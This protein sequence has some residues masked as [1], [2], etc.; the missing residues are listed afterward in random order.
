LNRPLWVLAWVWIGA[1]F[2][3]NTQVDR[4][5][6]GQEIPLSSPILEKWGDATVSDTRMF[7]PECHKPWGCGGAI[8]WE[9]PSNLQKVVVTA[10]IEAN[11]LPEG[12][13]E[14]YARIHLMQRDS[15]GALL[16]DL[17]HQVVGLHGS[18]WQRD[19]APF[20]LGAYSAELIAEFR[21]PT[22]DFQLHSLRVQTAQWSPLYLGLA[23]LLGVTGLLLASASIQI[24]R[25]ER[26]FWIP[27][28]VVIAAMLLPGSVR[29]LLPIS[30]H[31][32]HLLAFLV[33]AAVARKNPVA[34]LFTLAVAGEAIQTFTFDRYASWLD[35]GYDAIGIFL[36]DLIRRAIGSMD[37]SSGDDTE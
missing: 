36:G 18:G 16:W 11:G 26:R 28:T 30:D 25:P 8:R 4:L 12:D 1:V 9:L 5:I 3:V 2:A 6:P 17:P 20:R 14:R 33:L 37:A 22:G 29:D 7:V 24:E 31:T 21:A 13:P 27:A 34:V 23:G 10:E 15:S 32:A 35:V 19:S